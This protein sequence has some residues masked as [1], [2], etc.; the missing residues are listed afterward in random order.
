[1]AEEI[2]LFGKWAFEDLQ[3]TDGSLKDYIAV[4]PEYATYLPHHCW[5]LSGKAFPQGSLPYCGAFD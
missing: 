3:I 2:K 1:M 5:S 4:K